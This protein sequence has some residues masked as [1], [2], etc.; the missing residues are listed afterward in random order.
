[1]RDHQTFRKTCAARLGAIILGAALSLAASSGPAIADSDGDSDG[2]GFDPGDARS[3]GIM[4]WS[5]GNA[6]K[7]HRDYAEDNGVDSCIGCH[8]L[9]GVGYVDS[10]APGCLSC[11]GEKWDG[12]PP[13]DRTLSDGTM[14][15]NAALFGDPFAWMNPQKNHRDYVEEVG[16]ANCEGC[17]ILLVGG[18]DSPDTFAA[19]GCLSCHGVK[20]DD[21]DYDDYDDRRDHDD[22]D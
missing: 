10:F 13:F 2:T 14:D 17:H 12:G 16:T 11:H 15:M 3:A 5:M 4:P 19:P 7:T 9:G 18:K 22:S 20:W 1:M 8:D 21:D 6:Y